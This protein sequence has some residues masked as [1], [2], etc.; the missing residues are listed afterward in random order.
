MGMSAVGVGIRKDKT[1]FSWLCFIFF[2][3]S[4]VVTALY[5]LLLSSSLVL[6]DDAWFQATCGVD[7]A[8]GNLVH[9]QQARDPD[10]YLIP[11]CNPIHDDC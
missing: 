7:P 1:P 11:W 6:C 2:P 4:M 8:T 10:G 3:L 5:L 9:T